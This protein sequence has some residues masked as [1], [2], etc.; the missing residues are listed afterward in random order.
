MFCT[1]HVCNIL[2]YLNKG[3]LHGMGI[4]EKKVCTNNFGWK[5]TAHGGPRSR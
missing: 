2:K 4:K 1:T 3:G 5:T